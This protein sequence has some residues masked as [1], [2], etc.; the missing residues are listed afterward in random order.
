MK[1]KHNTINSASS[2]K[3]YIKMQGQ[4]LSNDDCA[5][6]L[7]EA[8]AKK[9]QNITWAIKVD[10]TQQKHRRI[11]RLSMD[12]FYSLVTGQPDAFY[13]MCMILPSIIEEVVNNTSAISVPVDTV[14]DELKNIAENENGSFTLAL[15]ILGFS[16]YNGFSKK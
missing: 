14:I 6:F 13:Q 12:E 11:R 1:N 15:Y 8:I 5:C 2:G 3:T 9:S 16:T 7:V 4:L 10:G